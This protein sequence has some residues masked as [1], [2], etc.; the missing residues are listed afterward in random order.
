MTTETNSAYTAATT[1]AS[2]GV[3]TP[4]FRPTM[5]MKG[6]TS[7]HAASRTASS[8]SRIDLRGGDSMLS[9]RAIHHHTTQIEAASMIPGKMPAKNS[10][11]IDTLAATPNTTKPIEGGKTGATIPAD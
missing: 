2:V 11:E 7:A 8:T 4:I 5:M 3:N 10:L 6:S 1:P 9:V